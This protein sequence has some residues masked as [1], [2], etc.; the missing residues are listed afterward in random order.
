M[1]RIPIVLFL[2]FHLIAGVKKIEMRTQ[3]PEHSQCLLSNLVSIQFLYL[4]NISSEYSV[5]SCAKHR[6]FGYLI[7]SADTIIEYRLCIEAPCQAADLVGYEI[8]LN[9]LLMF[10]VLVQEVTVFFWLCY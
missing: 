6:P 4:L 9:S 10:I 8:E 7:H 3:V 5:M 2:L 1:L